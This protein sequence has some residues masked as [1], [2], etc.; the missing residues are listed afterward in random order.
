M[1]GLFVD[2]LGRT[3]EVIVC[4]ESDDPRLEGFDGFT[5]QTCQQIVIADRSDEATV[6]DL[7]ACVMN[8][9]RHELVHAFLYESG[10]GSSWTHVLSGHDEEM[11]DWMAYQMPKIMEAYHSIRRKL[12]DKL[13]EEWNKK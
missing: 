10:L 9:L 3:W 2:V 11:V 4:T 5:D 13:N 8:T 6:K 12:A 1:D 7:M